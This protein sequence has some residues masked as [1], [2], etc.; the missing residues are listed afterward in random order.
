[1]QAHHQRCSSSSLYPWLPLG[2]VLCS[3]HYTWNCLVLC[4]GCMVF[5][6]GEMFHYRLMQ[7]PFH[8]SP[9]LRGLSWWPWLVLRC[10]CPAVSS[11]RRAAWPT[12]S[13]GPATNYVEPGPS[14]GP[15]NLSAL[16]SLSRST[17]PHLLSSLFIFFPPS[18]SASCFL[19]PELPLWGWLP[20]HLHLHSL[21]LYS[22]P[23]GLS[24][25][26]AFTFCSIRTKPNPQ[27]K[28]QRADIC[29][30]LDRSTFKVCLV[31][32]AETF[33][34]YFMGCGR[35]QVAGPCRA[36]PRRHEGPGPGR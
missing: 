34:L 25:Q 31:L 6:H 26:R 33:N 27:S 5:H 3:H 23:D 4:K 16:H 10:P 1:M 17:L 15:R 35:I 12:C 2:G 14:S 24:T 29:I 7:T 8:F 32:V 19:P 18:Y 30:F 20:T 22:H 28:I 13:V 21:T 36:A 11:L 9:G